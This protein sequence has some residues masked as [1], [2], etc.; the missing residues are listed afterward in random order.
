MVSTRQRHRSKAERRE[1]LIA[2]AIDIAS[3]Q[4]LDRLT[5]RD[6]AKRAEVTSGLIHHYFPSIDS[7]VTEAFRRIAT[8]D[9]EWLHDGLDKLEPHR[10]VRVFFERSIDPCRDPALAIWLSAWLAASRR[11]G[12]RD[13]A[14]EMMNS[15]VAALASILRRGAEAGIFRC[16][17]PEMSAQRILTVA[18]GFLIQRALKIGDVER[19]G[20][21]SFVKQTMEREI[22]ID[23]S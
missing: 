11:A 3:D 12:L 9:L 1:E 2:A 14:H 19:L 6:V 23:L 8:T 7:L 21:A 13:A 5:V 16:V 15:G 17:D 4:G 22:Q 10:A 20:L 18:D